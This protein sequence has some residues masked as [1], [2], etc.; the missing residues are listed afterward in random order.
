MSTCSME[1]N[2]IFFLFIFF[3][4]LKEKLKR[5]KD[6]FVLSENTLAPFEYISS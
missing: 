6:I 4:L 5:S 3:L 2:I 1:L